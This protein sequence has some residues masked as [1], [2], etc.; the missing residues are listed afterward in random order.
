MLL[1]LGVM[2]QYTLVTVYILHTFRMSKQLDMW[3]TLLEYR[4]KAIEVL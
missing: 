2:V 3:S 4:S 1:I